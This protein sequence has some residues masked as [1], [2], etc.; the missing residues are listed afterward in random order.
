M[1]LNHYP[2][3]TIVDII[4]K[5]TGETFNTGFIES[6]DETELGIV[7]KVHCPDSIIVKVG[8]Y[9]KSH[10][11]MQKFDINYELTRRLESNNQIQTI[12]VRV[13]I[14]GHN[15]LQK[16]ID[17]EPMP[18]CHLRFANESLVLRCNGL[19]IKGLRRGLILKARIK[20]IRKLR[21]LSWTGEIDEVLEI[22]NQA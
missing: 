8:L 2:V 10:L 5:T 14:V 20:N 16:T 18:F 15:H 17:D 4:D 9:Y 12:V 7:A 11:C 19:N 1:K 6:Y 22:Y 3:E 13:S 21:N